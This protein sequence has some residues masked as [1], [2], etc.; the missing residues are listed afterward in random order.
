MQQQANPAPVSGWLI[1]QTASE[2]DTGAFPDLSKSKTLWVGLL[3]KIGELRCPVCQGY[4]HI[5]E[6]C[7]TGL[8]LEEIAKGHP[9]WGEFHE[10]LMVLVAAKGIAVR[11]DAKNPQNSSFGG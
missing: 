5:E 8:R 11:E 4:G 3:S 1:L 9:Q 2:I 7:S 6:D 10:N